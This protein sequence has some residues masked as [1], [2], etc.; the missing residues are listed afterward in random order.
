MPAALMD[1]NVLTTNSER[2]ESHAAG[3]LHHDTIELLLIEDNPG[4]VVL[5]RT[6]LAETGATNVMLSHAT[7]L[8]HGLALLDEHRYSAVLTDLNLPDSDG[9]DTLNRLVACGLDA[10]VIVLTHCEDDP[11]AI[12]MVK[13]GAQDYL[14]KGQSDGAM[15]LKTVRYAIERKLADQH[16]NYLSHYDR[17][18]G[19]ANRE[20]FQDRLEQ[21]IV[22]ADRNG[23]LV[24][25]LFLD[26]DRFKAINDTLGHKVGDELLCIVANRL[27][28]SVRKV[29]TIA[30]LGGDEFTVVLEE[31]SSPYDAEM[32][33]RKIIESF[34]KPLQI[35]GRELYV[36]L[37]IGVTFFP[38]DATAVNDLLRNADTAM[39]R[40]KD[41]GRNK[42]HM[43]TADLNAQAVERLSIESAL[44]H[45]LDRDEL[46][47][48]YQP[49]INL[50]TGGI[51]GVEA[52]VRWRHPHR[53]LVSPV[54][55]IPVAEETGLIVPIGEWVLR[56]AC[57]DATRWAELGLDEV[58]VAVNLSARQFRQ[59]DLLK[60]VNDVLSEFGFDPNRLELEITES[61][62]MQ[63]MQASQIALYD[64]KAL[65]LE[66]YL[67]DFGTGY[68][69][70]AYL[71]K[72]PIDALK[73][74]RSFIRDIPGNTDDEAI[75]R[76][77]VA[78]GQALR[79]KVVA[80]GVETDAQ[81]GFLNREG[82]DEVQGFLFSKPL[83]FDEFIAWA[84]TRRVPAT[85]IGAAL[86]LD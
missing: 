75:T 6:M 43:F 64:L 67:D 25:L 18:T 57:A 3:Q 1:T 76:A 28:A 41:E 36:T 86:S 34:E 52:L 35:Q 37:S 44:R 10:P 79:L 12:E 24:A 71:K 16:L 32:V 80:E 73:I 31:I 63:D 62:L 69:S 82:C 39:Y 60:T 83:C 54:E 81:L 33:C 66:I 77:I 7:S 22:R 23:N 45:A 26:V 48:C 8:A 2:R 42:Y 20:L 65:G 51:A 40:A 61:L 13:L 19:L 59:G 9:I 70:L 72:F 58:D 84:Q 30:R 50:Q 85:G 49:K 68:S 46:F 21:A 38:Q 29:D 5:I 74:D 11:A 15:I 14:V 17:L 78:L 4:D 55:F 47:L 53:G 56:Q 27:Q